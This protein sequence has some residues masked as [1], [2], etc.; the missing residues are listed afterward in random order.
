M[1]GDQIQDTE[2]DIPGSAGEKAVGVVENR[3]QQIE[4]P[5]KGITTKISRDEVEAMIDAKARSITKP[6]SG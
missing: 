4:G 2:K 6:H 3:H 1:S 5:D